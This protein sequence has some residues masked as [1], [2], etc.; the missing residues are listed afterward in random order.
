MSVVDRE[1]ARTEALRRAAAYLRGRPRD[2]MRRHGLDFGELL[3]LKLVG[4]AY[5][6]EG[7]KV[8]VEPEDEAVTSEELTSAPRRRRFRSLC[9]GGGDGG[10]FLRGELDTGRRSTLDPAADVLGFPWGPELVDAGL[11]KNRK[12]PM[13]EDGRVHWTYGGAGPGGPWFA[14]FWW[15]N[16]V[17]S[18]PGSNSGFYVQGFAVDSDRRDLRSV[19]LARSQALAAAAFAFACAEWPDVVRRQRRPLVLQESP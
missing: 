10:H 19:A 17:D 1:E 13:V 12:V 15:D 11:L 18:R 8:P 7:V 3:G 6:G 2:E 9:F 16:S 14:F 5:G 4:G